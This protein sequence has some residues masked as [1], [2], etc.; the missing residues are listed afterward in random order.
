MTANWDA[1]PLKYERYRTLAT[2]E[3]S[4]SGTIV[5]EQ[6]VAVRPLGCHTEGAEE[7]EAVQV[8]GDV[9]AVAASGCRTNIEKSRSHD[10]NRPVPGGAE[11]I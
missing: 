1:S 5:V 3:T 6:E 10:R 11:G 8:A 4:D 9:K 7:A 2:H